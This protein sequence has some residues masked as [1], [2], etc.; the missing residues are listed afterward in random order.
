MVMPSTT[1]TLVGERIHTLHARRPRPDHNMPA[2]SD[3]TYGQDRRPFLY[4]VQF[5]ILP[6]LWGRPPVLQ[7]NGVA[8]AG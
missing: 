4:S 6:R 2:A 8:H 3:A 1:A 5:R 7:G